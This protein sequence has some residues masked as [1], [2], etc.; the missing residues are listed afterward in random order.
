LYINHVEISNFRALET[1]SVPLNK[2][3]VLIGENDVGKTSFLYALE[4]YFISKKIDE[5][6]DWF[7]EITSNDIRIVLTFKEIPEDKELSVFI[8]SNGTIVLSKVFALGKPPDVKAILDDNSAV[9]VPSA[10]LKQWFSLEI[11]HFIPVRRDL[12]VQFSMAKTALLGKTLRAKMKKTIDEGVGSDSLTNLEATLTSSLDEPKEELQKYLREQMHD[13]SVRLGFDE[14]EIDPIEGVSFKVKLSDDRVKG[15]L[16]QNRG[17]GTQNSLIIALFRLIAKLKLAGY[18]IFVMEEPENSLHPKAQRQL[19]SVIQEI[20]NESQVIVTT[21]S[22]VFIDRSKFENNI[23]LTRTSKGNTVAK[24]FD[25]SILNQIRT[26]LGIRA[27][28]ALLKGGGNCAIL[29]EGN[30]DCLL[31]TSPSPRDRTRSRMPSS[32]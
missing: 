1:V 25:S 13:N 17:A 6:T 12:A 8:R 21:H 4:K 29:V 7:K 27:S 2:F 26:D 3:S 31:Y 30:T 19:L 24:T 10:V 18:F 28:D 22:P 32:A 16:I 15:I 11:F 9:A 5:T 20:S 23:L 14:L